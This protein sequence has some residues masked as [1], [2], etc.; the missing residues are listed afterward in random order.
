MQTLVAMFAHQLVS[1]KG[2][3]DFTLPSAFVVAHDLHAVIAVPLVAF[4]GARQS[5][6][7][8]AVTCLRFGVG[9]WNDLQVVFHVGAL[10][11]HH[12]VKADAAL[13]DESISRVVVHGSFVA[14]VWLVTD[15]NAFDG[16]LHMLSVC[17]PRQGHVFDQAVELPLASAGAG[18]RE[19]LQ[20]A[21][22]GDSNHAGIHGVVAVVVSVLFAIQSQHVIQTKLG[23]KH[24]RHLAGNDAGVLRANQ[25]D[26]FA[27][28]FA[29]I[30]GVVE[31]TRQKIFVFP[32]PACVAFLAKAV[33]LVFR[34]L[35]CACQHGIHA[36][37]L[38]RKI[39]PCIPWCAVAFDAIGLA[40]RHG[41]VVQ[42]VVQGLR[43]RQDVF[44]LYLVG[45]QHVG[46]DVNPAVRAAAISRVEAEFLPQNHLLNVGVLD[47]LRADLQG[48]GNVCSQPIIA[49][50][51]FR[52]PLVVFFALLLALFQIT[53]HLN[54]DFARV[55]VACD[56]R[57]DHLTHLI[58][59]NVNRGIGDFSE[60][61]FG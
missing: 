52:L 43:K 20:Q 37:T 48:A 58:Q 60:A 8:N 47:P 31:R 6:G 4:V 49:F 26:I 19:A 61:F 25:A 45:Q 9:E 39:V 29:Q 38:C 22:V 50:L 30:A 27:G 40:H 42:A 12:F 15:P 18:L 34:H 32:Q 44:D 5:V 7:Q 3:D 1:L 16:A 24:G 57:I 55:S 54:N 41:F 23:A 10:P 35:L 13:S 56:K 2:G 28:D 46:A 53:R 21:L 17:R 36:P 51:V 33:T 11:F 59:A 14:V